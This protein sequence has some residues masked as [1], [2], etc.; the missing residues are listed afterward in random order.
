MVRRIVIEPDETAGYICYNVDSQEEVDCV[1]E[2]GGWEMPQWDAFR[3]FGEL[4][5]LVC[6]ANTKVSADGQTV[7]FFPPTQAEMDRDAARSARARRDFLLAQTDYLVMPDYPLSEE[8]RAAVL[9]YRQ[10]LRDVTEQPGWPDS[11]AW[12]EKPEV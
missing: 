11:V 7:E 10:A 12:P 4:Q 1:I 8:K 2:R 3:L 6:P 5:H 9:A